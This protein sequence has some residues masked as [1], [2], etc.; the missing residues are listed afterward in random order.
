MCRDPVSNNCNTISF[1]FCLD[2]LQK[3]ECYKISNK[4]NICVSDKKECVNLQLTN[5]TC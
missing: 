4:D 1:P 5:F 3:N 2:S